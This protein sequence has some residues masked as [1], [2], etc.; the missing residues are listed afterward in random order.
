MARQKVPVKFCRHCG[1]I[2][3]QDSVDCP[4]CGKNTIPVVSQK[5]CPFCGELV[6]ARAVKCKHCGEFLDGRRPEQA[7]A[8]YIEKAIITGGKQGAAELIPATPPQAAEEPIGTESQITGPDQKKLPA[9][10]QGQPPATVSPPPVPARNE[11]RRVSPP[12]ET[13]PAEG[14]PAQYDCPS[15][16]RYVYEGDNFCENCGRD[17]SIPRGR[18][19]KLGPPK[20]Y[21]ASDYALMLG[22]AAPVGLLVGAPAALAVAGAGALLSAWCLWRILNPNSHLSG[23]APAAGGLAASA[24]WALMILLFA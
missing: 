10:E 23:A 6:R 9:G 21:K 3:P 24:F 17:L 14:P 1:R 16:G 12:E 20:R 13:E 22:A 5:E 15:C 11:P 8:I 18:K 7:G 19:E 2:I 4:Y